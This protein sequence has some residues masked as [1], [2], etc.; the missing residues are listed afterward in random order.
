MGHQ[1]R[2]YFLIALL[3]M[4]TAC[5]SNPPGSLQLLNVS[6]DPTR[7]FYTAYN[8]LF[9]EKWQTQTG[10]QITI[11]QSHGGSSTQAR[12]I[13]DGLQADVTSLAIALDIDEIA[14]R[15]HLLPK[16]WQS[17]LPHHSSP[18]TSVVVFLVRKGNP[19]N[20]HDWGD[21]IRDDVAVITANPKT[22]GGARWNYLAAYGYAQREHPG[23]AVAAESFLR[24]LYQHVPVLDTASRAAAT[25]FAQREIGDVLITWENEASLVLKELGDRGFEIIRPPV[26][27]LT[28]PAVAWLDAIVERHG[29]REVA[30]AYLKGL[31]TPEAQRLAAQHGF[32]PADPQIE[33]EFRHIF[34]VVHTFTVEDL[35]G[36]PAIQANHF[37][38][39][40][41]F[42]QI[43]R[44]GER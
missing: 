18:Y 7:E 4:I 34:P 29:T 26:T 30:E 43:Y 1:W 17:R 36:W 8:Q 32:R 9:A 44:P 39:G 21:L 14:A 35:G 3:F 31:Y 42:D 19:K 23:D 6:Y 5:A 25:T 38:D 40:A 27:I 16:D 24:K 12:A 41:L 22:S 20:I 37:A 13:I 15:T 11:H 10:Q 2:S 28:E 33:A